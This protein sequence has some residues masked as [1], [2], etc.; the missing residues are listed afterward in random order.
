MK[1]KDRLEFLTNHVRKVLPSWRSTP[2]SWYNSFPHKN[3]ISYE[4]FLLVINTFNS[5]LFRSCL[6]TGDGYRLPY[7]L[8]EFKIYKYMNNNPYYIFV[9]NPEDS[10]YTRV[11]VSSQNWHSDG[12]KVKFRWIRPKKFNGFF[13]KNVWL[14]NLSFHNKKTIGEEM[15]K[16][17]LIQN[18]E[19]K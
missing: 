11:K 18:Y 16:R 8:G 7:R 5:L 3:K 17:N 6:E 14:W 19:R 12:Y 15:K 9:K 2:K 13:S 10:N 1:F 4:E